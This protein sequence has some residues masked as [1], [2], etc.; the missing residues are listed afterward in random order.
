MCMKWMHP[1]THLLV[2]TGLSDTGKT[3]SKGVESQQIAPKAK[4][5]TVAVME[6]SSRVSL[7]PAHYGRHLMGKWRPEVGLESSR[8]SDKMASWFL[9]SVGLF[10]AF[11]SG[12]N[13]E[14]CSLALAALQS[15]AVDTN[16]DF[17]EG[18]FSKMDQLEHRDSRATCS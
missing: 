6:R 16:V 10:I 14:N 15:N 13:G 4:T 3:E 2:P 5:V 9:L 12:S 18:D 1:S 8:Q 17:S 11:Y 7:V